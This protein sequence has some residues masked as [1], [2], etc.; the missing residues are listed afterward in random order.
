GVC[1]EQNTTTNTGTSSSTSET[2]TT[3]N[4]E[5]IVYVYVPQNNQDK[6]GDIQVLLPEEKVVPALAE[7]EYTVKVTDS[8]KKTI[9]D[10]DFHWSFGDGGEKF[11]RDVSYTYVYPGEYV[12]IASADGYLSGGKARM[13]VKVVKPDIYIEEIG[14]TIEENFIIL[15]NNTDYDLFLSNFYLNV[16]GNLLKLPKNLMIA[17]NK[18]LRL[19][20]EALGFKLPAKNISLLYPN[21]NVLTIFKETVSGNP[22]ILDL[23]NAT[24]GIQLEVEENFKALLFEMENKPKTP[25]TPKVKAIQKPIYQNFE[26]LS[27]NA[28]FGSDKKESGL[29]YFKRLVLSNDFSE[30]E[31]FNNS[32]I[33]LK[34]KENSRNTNVDTRLINWFKNLIYY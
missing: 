12:L 30:K 14:T 34:T 4:K 6:Y 33:S 20:G 21:K 1:G 32:N 15:K 17:K 23:V 18:S 11:G 3:T 5:K 9:S 10:L 2:G 8:S 22:S 28:E 13:N 31:N 16:D 26:N 24:S 25:E 7:V 19:S 29:V 27:K